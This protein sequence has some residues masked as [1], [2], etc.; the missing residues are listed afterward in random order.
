MGRNAGSAGLVESSTESFAG[1]LGRLTGHP[2]VE[3][4]DADLH[5]FA[6]SGENPGE[7]PDLVADSLSLS[8]RAMRSELLESART[9]ASA[10]SSR[11]PQPAVANEL[12]YEKALQI[13]SRRIPP[14][15][16]PSPANPNLK[17]ALKSA[18]AASKPVSQ[19]RPGSSPNQ[20]PK[21]ASAPARTPTAGVSDFSSDIST[22]PSAKQNL[23]SGNGSAAKAISSRP[24]RGGHE[25]KQE[26]I[27]NSSPGNLRNRTASR[28]TGSE[29]SASTG[30][31]LP[32]NNC[33]ARQAN[34]RS[35]KESMAPEVTSGETASQDAADPVVVANLTTKK[36]NA[37]AKSKPGAKS[38]A[39]LNSGTRSRASRESSRYSSSESRREL[40]SK[41]GGKHTGPTNPVA[42]RKSLEPSLDST[43]LTLEN[44]RLQPTG[45][46]DELELSLVNQR[47]SIVSI[48]LTDP[49]I[50]ILRDRADE[51]G[52]SVSAYMR[53]CVLEAETLRA[54]VKQAMAEMRSLNVA[55]GRQSY[56]ALAVSGNGGNQRSGERFRGFLRSITVL[57][58]PLL[59]FRRSA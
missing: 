39:S 53:S 35:I 50:A 5:S 49:E 54:Q 18:P 58:G 13:H 48:R 8:A 42:R 52:I 43:G 7:L 19:P 56:S 9:G 6:R 59:T 31:K 28:V 45:V 15:L 44:G 47:K 21:Q 20:A 24:A 41:S 16:A 3:A 38:D 2:I 36:R 51:S 57:L 23:G 25:S 4:T 29:K 27:L 11:R 1:L 40:G 14:P 33:E 17:P 32:Q 34:G 12:S 22:G 37:K 10:R 26:A 30:R 46:V 55:S